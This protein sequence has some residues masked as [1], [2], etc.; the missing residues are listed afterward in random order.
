MRKRATTEFSPTTT[1]V[2]APTTSTLAI[3]LPPVNL[4]VGGFV[5]KTPIQY[6]HRKV[7]S[8][9]QL[10]N[11]EFSTDFDLPESDK[12][13]NSPDRLKYHFFGNDRA[14]RLFGETS[15]LAADIN[16]HPNINF[17]YTPFKDHPKNILMRVYGNITGDQFSRRRNLHR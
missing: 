7:H 14:F 16:L 9:G 3:P 15:M 11:E 5:Y 1:E 13:T 10:K 4:A 8:P 6:Y 12:I 2:S 17:D